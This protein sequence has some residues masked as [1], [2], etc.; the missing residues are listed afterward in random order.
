[1]K[2]DMKHCLTVESIDNHIFLNVVMLDLLIGT[3]RDTA[4]HTCMR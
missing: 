3:V 2:N 1:M 4:P